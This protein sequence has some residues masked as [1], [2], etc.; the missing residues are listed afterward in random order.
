MS[1][2]F[3][4]RGTSLQAW[5]DI[6]GGTPGQMKSSSA[7]PDSVPTADG[8]PGSFGG[9]VL[10]TAHTSGVK[11]LQ[12]PGAKNWTTT[13][14]MAVLLRVVPRFSGAPGAYEYLM[15][16]SSSDG[17]LRLGLQ[18]AVSNTGNL[19]IYISNRYGGTVL[20]Y[21]ST[22]PLTLVSGTPTDLMFSWDGTTSTGS[23]QAS[24]DGV[25][26]DAITPASPVPS[27][28]PTLISGI[29]LADI[30]GGPL[31]N[32]DFNEVVIF[33]SPQPVV[34]PVRTAFYP[35]VAFDGGMSTNP[36]P[37]NVASGVSFVINGVSFV[38]QAAGL[39]NNPA[40]EQNI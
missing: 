25:L 36:G 39:N 6:S 24:Q 32:F 34:Y 3:Q 18:F 26:L 27:M 22:N 13:S 31:C 10:S 5:R 2:I 30:N 9:F 35:S 1:V 20:N 7:V 19:A 37:S 28:D 21:I 11:A 12:Y 23:F 38:G 16:V 8:N 17:S 29:L 14:Q 4:V 40:V 33:D 15:A